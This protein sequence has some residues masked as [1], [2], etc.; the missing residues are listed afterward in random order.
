MQITFCVLTVILALI[1]VAR[2]DVYLAI[3]IIT[4]LV[5]T[6]V[7]INFNPLARR[8]TKSIGI[9]LMGCFV[10]IMIFKIRETLGQG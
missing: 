3:Y 6:L 5:I 8:A 1:S 9:G 4:Y 2:L 10:I 7:F